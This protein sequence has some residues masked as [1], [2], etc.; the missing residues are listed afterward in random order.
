MKTLSRK[1]AAGVLI[2]GVLVVSAV[3]LAGA[4]D[5]PEV[6]YACKDNAQGMIRLVD[7]GETC[8]KTETKIW[9]NSAP[10]APAADTSASVQGAP[11]KPTATPTQ[12]PAP[13]AT[14]TPDALQTQVAALQGQVSTL[15]TQGVAQQTQITT[16]QAQNTALTTQVAA[17]QTPVARWQTQIPAL[18][19]PVAALQVQVPAL[20]TPVADLVMYHSKTVFVSSATY[21]GNLG[22]L[23][24]ADNKCQAL[25]TAAGLPGTYKAWL[26]DGTGSPSTRFTQHD[27]YYVLANGTKIADN[28][29]DLTD[30]SL[31]NR[32][33]LSESGAAVN[34][35]I[36]WTGT[37]TT[38][39]SAGSNCGNWSQSGYLNRGM[40][41]ASYYTDSWW[42][43]YSEGAFC[44][45]GYHLYCFEQ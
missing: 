16:L 20:R 41:G 13:T 12:P 1:L 29:T 18:Q 37:G 9:W 38:G 22:G 7:G 23:T 30:G 3:A 17:L 21:N 25:A 40:D 34:D 36:V 8:K 28:W 33:A 26:S 15:Q 45:G 6:F 44:E 11:A 39:A 43:S 2:A 19:T 35:V 14:P 5:N 32:I 10:V 31:A 27:F 42:T 24:G 4:G